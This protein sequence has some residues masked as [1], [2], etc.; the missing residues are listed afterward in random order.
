MAHTRS[1][2]G[3]LQTRCRGMIKKL[4]RSKCL[5]FLLRFADC[6]GLQSMAAPPVHGMHARTHRQREREREREQIVVSDIPRTR[7]ARSLLVIGA[8]DLLG[9]T[10]LQER[11]ELFAF[12]AQ[13]SNGLHGLHMVTAVLAVHHQVFRLC[14]ASVSHAHVVY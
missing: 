4:G 5:S 11:F 8:E 12:F 9:C 6:D 2:N 3:Y 13:S 1:N 7:T 14:V 10:Y